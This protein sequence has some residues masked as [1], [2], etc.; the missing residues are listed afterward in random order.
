MPSRK[1][2][3]LVASFMDGDDYDQVSPYTTDVF[4]NKE[5]AIEALRSKIAIGEAEECKDL[6]IP[7]EFEHLT[8]VYKVRSKCNFRNGFFHYVIECNLIE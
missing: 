5:K 4:L 7:Q 1:A 2:Y 8:V 6:T 3:T